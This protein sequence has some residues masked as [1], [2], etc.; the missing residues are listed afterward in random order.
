MVVIARSFLTETRMFHLMS[1]RIML[2]E[3]RYKLVELVGGPR[4]RAQ[5]R[6][7]IYGDVVHLITSSLIRVFKMG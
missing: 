2:L 4:V 5:Q 6:S 3:T 1:P 7:K